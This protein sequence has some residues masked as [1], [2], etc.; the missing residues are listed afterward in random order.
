MLAGNAGYMATYDGSSYRVVWA[1]S[2][3]AFDNDN[4]AYSTSLFARSHTYYDGGAVRPMVSLKP[5]TTYRTGGEGTPAKP[6][7]IE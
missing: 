1:M 6:Y 7:I 4:Y 5:G 2:P 3:Y